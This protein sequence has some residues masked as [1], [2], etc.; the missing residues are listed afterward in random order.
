MTLTNR[1]NSE[2]NC[3]IVGDNDKILV[4]EVFPF[5]TCYKWFVD[6][7]ISASRV[8]FVNTDTGVH[9]RPIGYTDTL[10]KFFGKD[11]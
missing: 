9:V 10:N 1:A 3:I 4:D 2:R 8:L 6:M 5:N 11:D 7:G